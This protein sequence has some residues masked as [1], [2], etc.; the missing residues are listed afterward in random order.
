M[1]S[2]LLLNPSMKTHF[3]KGIEI[4]FFISTYTLA[5]KALKVK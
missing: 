5:L 4:M 1:I 2:A 3:G